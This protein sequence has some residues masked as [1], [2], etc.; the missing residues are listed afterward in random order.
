MYVSHFITIRNVI[1]ASLRKP[2]TSVTGLHMGMC[3]FA[4]LQPLIT[5]FKL[6]QNNKHP[7][8]LERQIRRTCRATYFWLL[9]LR[10]MLLHIHERGE[11]TVKW[12]CI[13]PE[14]QCFFAWFVCHDVKTSMCY[15]FRLAPKWW[16]ISLVAV[17]DNIIIDFWSL[18]GGKASV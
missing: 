2:H 15:L 12:N 5:N 8:A 10:N 4:C 6:I 14:R 7:C 16:I 18:F 11:A 9:Q 13:N 3:T 17:L 1:R